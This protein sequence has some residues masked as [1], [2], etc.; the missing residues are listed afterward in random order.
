MSN[1]HYSE[2]QA[3]HYSEIENAIKQNTANIFADTEHTREQVD[4]VCQKL[5]NGQPVERGILTRSMMEYYVKGWIRTISNEDFNECQVELASGFA[6]RQIS[7]GYWKITYSLMS[8]Q[9]RFA[10][11]HLLTAC[12][13]LRKLNEYEQQF[14]HSMES[15]R[16]KEGL[17]KLTVPQYNRLKDIADKSKK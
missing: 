7:V 16:R 8:I 6:L 10:T 4:D 13:N 5:L 15:R 3:R 11:S 1:K 12:E 9:E 2:R 17:A 14:I